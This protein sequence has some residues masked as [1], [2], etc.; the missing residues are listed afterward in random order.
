[1]ER[2]CCFVFLSRG[3]HRAGRGAI[4]R[5]SLS[6]QPSRAHEG[7]PNMEELFWKCKKK[8]FQHH[9]KQQF[10]IFST[11]HH[12]HRIDLPNFLTTWEV[13]VSTRDTIHLRGRHQQTTNATLSLSYKFGQKSHS[14]YSDGPDIAWNWIF[15]YP[16][17]DLKKTQVS[18]TQISIMMYHY[19]IQTVWKA[20]IYLY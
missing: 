4:Y 9:N 18:G 8:F 14:N 11:R 13:S 6:K 2:C 20:G 7:P 10:L 5:N 3:G 12:I 17:N 15:G 19:L 1:M 16:D